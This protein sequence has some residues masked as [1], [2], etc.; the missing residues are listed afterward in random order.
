[1]NYLFQQREAWLRAQFGSPAR[2]HTRC[3]LLG[4]LQRGWGYLSTPP[5][6]AP[7]EDSSACS[8]QVGSTACTLPASTCHTCVLMRMAPM[9][10]ISK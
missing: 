4:S 7:R 9:E 3:Q 2:C 1:M 8:C 5:D 10:G 6:R